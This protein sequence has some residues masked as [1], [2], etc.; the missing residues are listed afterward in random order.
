VT[1][2]SDGCSVSPCGT[3]LGTSET[4][5]LVTFSS[6][7]KRSRPHGRS[8][9]CSQCWQ[10][11]CR[12]YRQSAASPLALFVIVILE[13]GL[14]QRSPCAPDGLVVV[15]RPK[16]NMDAHP[17]HRRRNVRPRLASCR[18]ST[19][20]RHSSRATW[21]G[22]ERDRRPLRVHLKTRGR[23]DPSR[24][25]E[26]RGLCRRR[27]GSRQRPQVLRAR[28]KKSRRYRRCRR[29]GLD[30]LAVGVSV[31]TM[32]LSGASTFTTGGS[33]RRHV[34][35]TSNVVWSGSLDGRRDGKP[36]RVLRHPPVKVGRVSRAASVP[37]SRA[38]DKK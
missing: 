34:F 27:L 21:R 37:T 35:T 5:L 22:G 18:S 10:N 38:Q 4:T 25:P 7:R 3:P 12:P 29:L 33:W 31:E 28:S 8:R 23:R 9:R 13:V 32:T 6:F 26:P 36:G 30:E 15:S 1:T 17:V 16:P 19:A 20:S 14:G 24:H 2:R 11:A